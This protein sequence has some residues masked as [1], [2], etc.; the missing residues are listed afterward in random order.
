MSN[1]PLDIALYARVKKEADEKYKTHGAFKSGWIVRTYKERGGKYS[2][3][4]TKGGL[5]AWFKEKWENVA[6]K[7]QKPVLRPTKRV[8]KKTP[9][10]VSEISKAEIEKQIKLKQKIKGK[11]NL[12]AFKPK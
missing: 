3:T 5:S 10:T 4:K 9:L 2:G 12:P 11:K 7:G 8:S 6:G 1:K